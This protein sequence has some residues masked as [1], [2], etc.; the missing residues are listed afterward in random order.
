MPESTMPSGLTY[1]LGSSFPT[2]GMILEGWPPMVTYLSPRISS[3][4]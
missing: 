3:S 2:R 1:L 4:E